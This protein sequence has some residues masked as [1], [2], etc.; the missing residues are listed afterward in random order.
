MPEAAAALA[1]VRL[2]A[3]YWSTVSQR[4]VTIELASLLYT[5]NSTSHQATVGLSPEGRRLA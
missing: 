2:P 4:S 3:A 1:F 5:S